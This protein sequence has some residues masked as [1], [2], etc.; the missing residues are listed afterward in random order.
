MRTNS[1]LS[2]CLGNILEWYDFG[3]F[4]IFS[5][6][7]GEIFF[8]KQ[9]AN[10]AMLATFSVFAIGFFCRPIGA[11]VFGYLGDRL[12]RA[13]TIRLSIL[14]ISL[15]TLLIGCIP[16]YRAAGILAPILLLMTR[17]WQGISLGGEYSGNIIYLG[18]LAPPK[19][20]SFFTALPAVG[21][22]IG[23]LMAML[24]GGCT[25]YFFN[26]ITFKAWG[27]RVPYLI[28]GIFCLLIYAT[29]LNI[30]ET[31]AFL[32]IKKRGNISTNPIFSVFKYHRYDMLRTLGLVCMGSTF[33]YFCFIYLPMLLHTDFNYS[34][35]KTTHFETLLIAGMILLIPLAGWLN[36]RIGRYRMLIFNATLITMTIVPG[37][38]ILHQGTLTTVISILIFFTVA[39]SLEQGTT[40]AVLVENFPIEERYTGISLAYN[41]ANGFLG[42]SIPLICSWLVIHTHFF[43]SPGFYVTFC[44]SI[45]LLFALT[46]RKRIHQ[47]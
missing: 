37:L 38:L 7:F 13:K 17:I 35:T 26:D 44:A 40:P 4:A 18:E 27:W 32:A 23:I 10:A 2:S 8:P 14:M 25:T 5:S 1:I 9:D 31:P 3:L 42:G 33:Y 29:R 46:F 34:L 21:A 24:V 11:L 30:Q 47:N 22:N 36:D 28:S 19:Q 15:P 16:D 45:T 43:L 39:S 12:G 20:R 6:L 41:I